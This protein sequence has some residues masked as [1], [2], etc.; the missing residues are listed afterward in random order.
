MIA[1]HACRPFNFAKESYLN[2]EEE[3]G[4]KLYKQYFISLLSFQVRA[5]GLC[6]CTLIDNGEHTL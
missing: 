5:K 4:M 1:V 6:P 2:L 3:I